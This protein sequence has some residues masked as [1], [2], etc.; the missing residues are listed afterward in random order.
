M[1][2]LFVLFVLC[3]VWFV[4]PFNF[5]FR[6]YSLI[7]LL[8]LSLLA[9]AVA[10]EEGYPDCGPAGST[11][12]TLTRLYSC[13]DGKRAV[14]MH[15]ASPH[16]SFVCLFVFHVHFFLAFHSQSWSCWTKHTPITTQFCWSRSGRHRHSDQFHGFW[17]LAGRTYFPDRKRSGSSIL[18]AVLSLVLPSKLAELALYL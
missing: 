4:L 14:R 5:F 7:M 8:F 3:L 11:F 17:R 18:C 10:T 16:Y 12:N 15:Q 6:N 9:L 13:N 2:C 1:F